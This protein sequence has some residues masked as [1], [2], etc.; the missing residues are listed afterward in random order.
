MNKQTF[1]QCIQDLHMSE[2][3]VG[4]D[5]PTISEYLLAAAPECQQDFSERPHIQVY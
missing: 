2:F 1:K 3:E 5:A 4:H